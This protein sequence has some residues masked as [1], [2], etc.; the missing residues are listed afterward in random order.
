[1]VKNNGWYANSTKLSAKKIT[2]IS[3]LSAI[4]VVFKFALGFIPGIEIVT[5]L[6]LIYA[7]FLPY[8]ESLIVV[9]I[10]NIFNLV[11]YGFGFWWI[12]YWPIFITNVSIGKIAKNIFKNKYL[13]ALVAFILGFSIIF[14]FYL[15]DLIWFGQ[16]Y[17]FSN[18][19]S[20][21]PVNLVEGF[22]NFLFCIIVAPKLMNIL[23]MNIVNIWGKKYEFH[24]KE[25]KHK[26]INIFASFF[27]AITSILGISIAFVYNNTF[28]Q[29][30]QNARIASN[31]FTQENNVNKNLDI[32]N[33]PI[34]NGLLTQESLAFLQSQMTIKD[35]VTAVIFNNKAYININKNSVGENS[36]AS[37]FLSSKE[38]NWYLKGT[39][40]PTLGLFVEDFYVNNIKVSNNKIPALYFTLNKSSENI[41]SNVGVSSLKLNNPKTIITLTYDKDI[42]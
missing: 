33:L 14:W 3:L 34:K 37:E 21:L 30:S 11:F 8:K 27:L 15:S 5:S 13:L 36:F 22:S 20:A 29:F 35:T 19:L 18:I 9:F 26:K 12:M 39:N 16:A 24:F 7:I 32:N 17:A 4:L 28:I 1:M 6:F 41:F 31:T 10:F 2:T 40:Y 42:F 23:N 25:T 38:N